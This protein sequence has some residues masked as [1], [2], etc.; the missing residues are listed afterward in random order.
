MQQ[1]MIFTVGEIIKII[2]ETITNI[3]GA[4]LVQHYGPVFHS[5]NIK[6]EIAMAS[7]RHE[8]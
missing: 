7:K 8:Y 5:T 6:K 1:Q 4:E 3:I 2:V